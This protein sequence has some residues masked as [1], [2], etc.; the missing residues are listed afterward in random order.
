MSARSAAGMGSSRYPVLLILGHTDP[1]AQSEWAGDLPCE[2]RAG[3]QTSDAA[4]DLTG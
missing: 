2:V 3:Q 4:Q 1:G